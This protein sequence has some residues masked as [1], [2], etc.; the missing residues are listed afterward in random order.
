[1]TQIS[2]PSSISVVCCNAGKGLVQGQG[3]LGNYQW[4]GMKKL[5]GVVR[6]YRSPARRSSSQGLCEHYGRTVTITVR[7]QRKLGRQ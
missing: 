2:F 5:E 4:E 7:Q 6:G 3:A 1:M